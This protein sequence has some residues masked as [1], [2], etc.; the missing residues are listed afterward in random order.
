MLHSDLQVHV[1]EHITVLST[2]DINSSMI[3]MYMYMDACTCIIHTP[4]TLY[5]YACTVEPLLVGIP[6]LR[7]PSLHWTPTGVL[8]AYVHLK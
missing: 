8:Y 5:Q 6:E 7:A 1:H 2:N 4:R 3:H